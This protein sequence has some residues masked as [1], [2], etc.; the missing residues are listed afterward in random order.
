VHS[1]FLYDLAPNTEYY[2]EIYYNNAVQGSGK[3]LTLPSS[4]LERNILIA[5]GGDVGTSHNAFNMTNVMSNYPLDVVLIGGDLGYD[6]GMRSCYYSVD[7][8]IKMFENLNKQV[9]RVVPMMVSVGNHDVGFN[10]F[11]GTK[12]DISQ[13]LYFTYFPQ[14]SKTD[15]DGNLVPQ[16]AD[17]PDRL[18]YVYH[19]L[20]NTVHLSLDSGY[21][22]GYD[23]IQTD[24]IHEVSKAYPN[25]VKMANFHV[26]MY[27]TCFDPDYDD[28]RTLTDSRKY[29]GPLFEQYKFASIFENHVH[30]YKAT[31]P[32]KDGA[33]NPDGDGVMY[34]G[35]G[36]WGI[37]TN[38]C[39]EYGPDGNSTYGGEGHLQAYSNERHVWL[40]NITSDTLSHY[41]VNQTGDIFDQKYDL[42]VSNYLPNDEN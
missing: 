36:N 10:A 28:I 29:W 27:P 8:F 1:A 12:I 25:L 31:F 3:Y 19:T 17:L 35:D 23:G 38:S 18:S 2:F 26:P 4:K 6:N 14:H 16:V 30:L 22:L 24:F 41:A 21:L 32:I 11:Q 15:A 37:S 42:I 9:G 13:N 7:L 5:S 33:P 34:F 20:G 39:W 40:I